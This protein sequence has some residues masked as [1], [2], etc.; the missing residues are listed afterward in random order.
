MCRTVSH[1]VLR[2]DVAG[3]NGCLLY[4]LAGRRGKKDLSSALIS[5]LREFGFAVARRALVFFP[6]SSHRRVEIN[7]S[8]LKA[9]CP[10]APGRHCRI[11]I[12]NRIAPRIA[13]TLNAVATASYFSLSLQRLPLKHGIAED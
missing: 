5:N 3:D 8:D 9:R 7:R 1:H 2:A 11:S 13:V 12:S 6:F 10:R 4:H